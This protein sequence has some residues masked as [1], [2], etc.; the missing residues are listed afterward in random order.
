MT[1]ELPNLSGANGHN[2]YVILLFSWPVSGDRQT[3][4]PTQKT[5]SYIVLYDPLEKIGCFLQGF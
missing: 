3:I 5:R 1:C 4:L 2:G